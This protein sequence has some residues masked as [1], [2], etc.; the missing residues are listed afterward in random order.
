MMK[1]MRIDER[2]MLTLL[3]IFVFLY[4]LNY[5]TPLG[6]GDDYLYSFI[7][8]GN[9]MNTPLSANAARVSSFS[10]LLA[11]QWSHYLTWGGRSVAH[12]LAQLF[13]WKG[14]VGFNFVN[15]FVG[16]LLVAEIYWCIHK[17]KV[18]FSF[19][20]KKVFWIFFALWAFTPGF[21][22][23]F[24]WLTG[25]CNY[26]WTCVMLLGFMVPFIKKYYFPEEQTG[27]SVFFTGFM[28]FFG[29]ISG[30]TNENS[31]CWI[32]L[33]LFLFL[34]RLHKHEISIHNWMYAG[35]A[36]LIIG[37]LLLVLSPGN[38]SRLYLIH[39][40][41]W[42]GVQYIKTNCETLLKVMICQFLLWYFL[43]RFLYG[44]AHKSSGI[45][46]LKK[47]IL[48]A[49]ALGVISLGTSLVMLLAPEFPERSGFFGTVFL[50]IAAG[51]VWQIQEEYTLNLI[52]DNAKKFLAVTGVIYFVM[53][54]V[55]TLRN[56]SETNEWQQELLFH[57]QQTK[58]ENKNSVLS[59]RP[60]RKA[61]KTEVLMSGFH[62]VENDL[63]D[64]AGSW[65]N[66]AFARYYGIKGVRV[67]KNNNETDLQH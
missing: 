34:L 66:V 54:F 55:I 5:L 7:W 10:D 1:K 65:E 2:G 67:E 22:P 40:T 6:F 15:A 17:G 30:W 9:A 63:S 20:P 60:F 44:T 32:I 8:Q 31:V 45:E 33:M 41:G 50:I 42:D 56:F 39:G 13:L 49:S 47:E 43:L 61:G 4:V 16:T 26:L 51:T 23:V 53:T 3:I 38:V 19:E 35:L 14:K 46:D 48:F 37:Y 21:T 64:D 62:I 18:S 25:A 57:V 27:D 59:V 12:T 24:L 11:S 28:F 58:T 29:I 36:G 52:R